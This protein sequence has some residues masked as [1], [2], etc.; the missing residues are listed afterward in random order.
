[1][2]QLALA[3]TLAKFPNTVPIPGTRHIDRLRENIGAINVQ[4]TDEDLNQIDQILPPG[5]AAGTRYPE[6][7]MKSLNR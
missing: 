5:S 7:G 3:W 1:A 4:L 2:A 6:A